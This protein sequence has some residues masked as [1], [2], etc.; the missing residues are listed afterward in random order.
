MT[1]AVCVKCGGM[2]V[3]AL[4]WC[5]VCEFQPGNDSENDD[6]LYSMILSDH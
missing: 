3:G 2:K 6:D 4:T 1:V 5:P